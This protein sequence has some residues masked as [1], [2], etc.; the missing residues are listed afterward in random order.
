MTTSKRIG[1]RV[2]VATAASAVL[3][4]LV[5][6]GIASE[7]DKSEW[8]AWVQ[9]FGSVGAIVGSYLI[10]R[11]QS[12]REN[13]HAQRMALLAKREKWAAVKAV[14]DDIYHQCLDVADQFDDAGTPL[15]APF[16]PHYDGR[17]FAKSL[18]RVESIPVFE[19]SSDRLAGP[20]IDYQREA[21][22]VGGWIERARDHVAG[23]RDDDLDAAHLKTMAQGA[24][25]RLRAA[26]A[27]VIDITGLAAP[28]H[29]A[30]DPATQD[31]HGR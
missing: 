18:E 20:I 11:W 2:A 29:A 14:L 25:A 28:E 30:V 17:K 23:K 7:L 13:D 19:L 22:R 10:G 1:K 16:A 15:A 8:A 5:G 27:D 21:R 26:Y 4:T 24:L 12:E 6:I 9:A 3:A 31:R